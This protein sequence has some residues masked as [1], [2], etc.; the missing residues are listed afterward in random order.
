MAKNST[1]TERP[2]HPLGRGYSASYRPRSGTHSSPTPST[3]G[4]LAHQWSITAICTSKTRGQDTARAAGR[5]S[6]SRHTLVC[7]PSPKPTT[8]SSRQ[9]ISWKCSSKLYQLVQLRNETTVKFCAHSPVFFPRTKRRDKTGGHPNERKHYHPRG[10]A[11]HRI[12][13]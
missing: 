8:Q 5:T 6:C 9:R 12:R 13:G 4:M 3:H 7:R 1:G 10:W 2:S 11:Q